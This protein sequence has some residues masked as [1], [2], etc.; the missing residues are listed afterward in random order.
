MLRYYNP[1]RELE[2]L[3]REVDRI[4]NGYPS[5]GLDNAFRSTVE[6]NVYDNAD[7]VTVEAVLP[8][9]DPKALE[10]T[11]LRNELTVSGERKAEE[12]VKAEAWHRQERP[13]GKFVR[14]VALPAEV[15]AAKVKA[16]YKDG[17][18]TVRMAKSEAA[19]PRR[20]EVAVA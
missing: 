11:V 6:V 10:I 1:L 3:R 7:D 19:R 9:V 16:E 12:G 15:D 20:I 18:L 8:G 4:F 17:I 13:V 5:S 2:V 14:K